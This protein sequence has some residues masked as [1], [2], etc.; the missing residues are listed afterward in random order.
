[1]VEDPTDPDGV[2]RRPLGD[3]APLFRGSADAMAITSVQ[4]GTYLDVNQA[5]EKMSGRSREEVL[6]KS[7]LDLDW[8]DASERDRMVAELRATGSS[9]PHE[10]RFKDAKGRVRHGSYSSIVIDYEGRPAILTTMRDVTPLREAQAAAQEQRARW[11]TLVKNFPGI[12]WS[13]DTEMRYTS[14]T[15]ELLV[16]RGIAEDAFVGMRVDEPLQSAEDREA[17][18]EN[19]RR[20][21]SGEHLNYDSEFSGIPFA[22]YLT[23]LQDAEGTI[24]GAVGFAV[25]I[26][27]RRVAESR[28]L[29]RDER[30]Q[31]LADNM[32]G[33]IFTTDRELVIT[34]VDGAGT[35]HMDLP[36]TALV[37][38]RVTDVFGAEDPAMAERLG[39]V[40]SGETLVSDTPLGGRVFELYAQPMIVEGKTTGI[41]GATNDVTEDRNA[42]E[43][44]QRYVERLRSLYEME[45]DILAARG[46]REIAS[47]TVERL[48]GMTRC[49]HVSVVEFDDSLEIATV[50]AV[51][52]TLGSG[53]QP[54]QTSTPED[55]F[56][57]LDDLR[58]GKRRSYDDI[59]A[60][61]S[62]NPSLE[63][64]VDQG[65]RSLLSI[66]LITQ[67]ELLGV[68]NVA[69]TSPTEMTEE[70]ITV[71]EEAATQLAVA[72]QQSRL[73]DQVSTYASELEKSLADLRRTDAERRRLLSR[74][75]EA[76]EEER[77]TI[78]ADIHDDTL[79]KMAAVG[80]RLD[81]LRRRLGDPA[82]ADEA[83]KLAE[84]VNLTI[85]RM[86]HLMFNLWPGTLDQHGLAEAIRVDL[87][88][89]KEGGA[90]E[91]TLD[92][93]STVPL[94]MEIRTI[95]YRI[96]QEALSNVRKHSHASKVGVFL[97]DVEGGIRVRVRDNG[98][99]LPEG[100]KGSPPGH[101]GISA[102]G[103]RAALAGGWLEIAPVTGGGTQ[104]EF[105]LPVDG[106]IS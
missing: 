2:P 27:A 22:T 106:A 94:S 9:G 97:D 29:E 92:D 7:A 67:G 79:Q 33:I 6:G 57:N 23:P 28:V 58:N 78:A 73:R 42:Q 99:G 63:P 1:M 36:P 100:L 66:P 4:D 70:Q 86:R 62:F 83:G 76:Q 101:L 54:G 56:D 3:L 51:A 102:M 77:R 71:T 12:A 39:S 81:V 84:I 74:L 103:E 43:A 95:A 30:L 15:G 24:T 37:G 88:A 26:T 16:S 104:I 61:V 65:F 40:L 53:A 34:S 32:P 25:D 75:V 49:E 14:I 45:R 68:L 38:R 21:L 82:L 93:R 20:A 80:L 18:L 52:S 48:Q 35:Q 98:L 89:M 69:S 72:I 19:H 8:I 44:T 50:R 13:V 96:V 60:A 10:G 59:T 87:I 5:F 91:A 47:S 17:A 55:L 105:F 90:I 46:V 41:I 11:A 85:D 64:L 31:M